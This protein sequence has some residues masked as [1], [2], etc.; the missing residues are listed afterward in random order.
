M[1]R[2]TEPASVGF[3]DVDSPSLRIYYPALPPGGV[4]AR[5]LPLD[6]KDNPYRPVLFLHGQRERGE[7]GL[8][9]LD[10]TADHTLWGTVLEL[11]ARCGFVV[12]AVNI[13]DSNFNPE[14]AAADA[15]EGLAWARNSWADRAVIK[16]PPVVVDPTHP[17]PPPRVG[18]IGHSWGAKAAARLAVDRK[19]RCVVGVS[20]TFDD[21]ESLEAI[22][23]ARVPTLLIAATNEDIFTIA[24]SPENQPFC[25]LSQPRHQVSLLG[26]GHWDLSEI[27]PCDGTRPSQTAGSRVIAAEVIT[28][29]LHRYL[30]NGS[31]LPPSLLTAPAG[32]R[33][34]ITPHVTG[35][36][37]AAVQS[38][39]QDPFT[40]RSGE[41]ILG[42]WPAGIAPWRQCGT[43]T[44]SPTSLLFGVVPTGTVAKRSLSIRNG[45]E[46]PVTL[47]FPASGGPFKWEAF[48]GTLRPNEERAVTI[49][50]KP[51]ASAPVTGAL[52]ITSTALGSPHTIRMTG[53]GTG[54]F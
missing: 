49:S 53:K 51:P 5:V 44:F 29:F 11:P 23:N 21:N 9:P 34:P 20:G 24:A 38:R 37:S 10:I 15:L 30:Y 50:F 40:A 33:P 22:R 17:L 3:R 16:E 28:V 41:T 43:L 46:N 31:T 45:S 39:W 47:S 13:S 4:N 2:L 18:A 6:N 7:G 19:V 1:S 27:G 42:S 54:G 26:I 36:G 32:G 8:C 52:T 12:V 35:A 14:T 25:V 48:N